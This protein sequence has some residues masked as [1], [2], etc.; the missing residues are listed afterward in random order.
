M[1]NYEYLEDK[2]FIIVSHTLVEGSSQ[3]LYKFLQDKVKR[4]VFLGHPLNYAD[5]VNS[6][7]EEYFRGHKSRRREFLALRLPEK[8]SY[9]KDFFMT[10]FAFLF[11]RKCFDIFVGVDALNAFAGFLLKKLGIVKKV[12]FYTIDYFPHRFNNKFL[13]LL[14]HKVDSYC[15]NHSDF[16]WNVS[17]KIHKARKNKGVKK[18]P[19]VVPVGV[20]VRNVKRLP[21]N[22]IDPNT[23]VYVGGLEEYYGVQ[24]MIE[25]MPDILKINP[26][27]RFIII[28]PPS[29]VGYDE[30]LRRKVDELEVSN[31]VEFLGLISDQKKLESIINK[32][33]FG[34]ALYLPD[35]KNDWKKYADVTKPK[36]YLSFGLPVL[37]TES[38][39]I[40]SEIRKKGAGMVIKPEKIQIINTVKY[41]FN[42]SN[43]KRMKAN[44]ERVAWHYDW[45]NIFSK[46][47]NTLFEVE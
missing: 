44:A 41:L 39:S 18:E 36:T 26:K 22:K 21:F 13:D 20:E 8:L 28:G 12:V 40:S 1:K 2:S 35:E 14:Y 3:G 7:Y 45:G 15:A 5:K 42:A 19:I 17:S 37:M 34:V 46:S 25:A 16:V 30:Y 47:L 4:V 6:F 43:L 10:F 33:A 24:L 27:A 9:I 23:F 29:S 32:C 11:I 31:H 38:L